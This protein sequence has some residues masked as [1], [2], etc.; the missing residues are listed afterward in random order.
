MGILTAGVGAYQETRYVSKLSIIVTVCNV[1]ITLLFTETDSIGF[2]IW[3][4]YSIF[5]IVVIIQDVRKHYKNPFVA[6]FLGSKTIGSI[7]IFLGL[8]VN[9]LV[10]PYFQPIYTLM[11][12]LSGSET[13]TGIYLQIAVHVFGVLV[14]L[15]IVHIIGRIIGTLHKH[16][17]FLF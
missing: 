10:I 3:A 15:F 11:V 6:F 8:T 4:I 17:K 9:D 1:I 16:H 5:G 7:T 12:E 14:I 2:Y 13:L